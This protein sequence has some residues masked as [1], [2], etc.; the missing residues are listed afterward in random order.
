MPDGAREQRV[1]GGIRNRRVEIPIGEQYLRERF[2]LVSPSRPAP[3]PQMIEALDVRGVHSPLGREP[4][5]LRLEQ[6][7][8]LI[9]VTYPAQCEGRD[10]RAALRRFLDEPFPHQTR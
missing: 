9:E 4:R 6:I 3:P 2:V 1:A 8:H 7:A 5:R 10:D